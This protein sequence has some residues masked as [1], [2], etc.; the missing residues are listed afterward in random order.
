MDYSSGVLGRLIEELGRLPGVGP[1]T[2][3]RLAFF[4]LRQEGG[5]VR[6]LTD[7]I[8]DAQAKIHPCAEC[9]FLAEAERCHLCSDP[10][11]DASQV[12]V[13][14]DARDVFSLERTR[15][16]KGLY[17]VLMGTLSP[18]DGIGPGDLKIAELLKRL[19]AGTVREVII[20][21]NQDV[22]GEA[23]ALYLG[24]L[25]KPLNIRVTRLASGLPAGG[26]LEYADDITIGRALSGRRELE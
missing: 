20:A 3:Q 7:S 9:F 24:R 1:K 18:M 17:H 26:D 16:Y 19:Q 15:E 11:R 25:I 6:R 21:T 14:E 5:A 23:T 10:K 8:L 22:E 12:C 2:A 4:L 13:V